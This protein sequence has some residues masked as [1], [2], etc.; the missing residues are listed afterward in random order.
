MT[1]PP[2]SRSGSYLFCNVGTAPIIFEMI[3]T[4][5]KDQAFLGLI[6]FSMAMRPAHDSKQ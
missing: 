6:I 4:L 2:N 5:I 1:P 3:N